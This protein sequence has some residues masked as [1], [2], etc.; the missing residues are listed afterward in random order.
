MKA[1]SAFSTFSGARLGP[2]RKNK[3]LGPR[4]GGPQVVTFA[5]SHVNRPL[6]SRPVSPTALPAELALGWSW[7]MVASSCLKRPTT[8]IC[9]SR[10][11]AV[12]REVGERGSL[13]FSWLPSLP[14]A[15]VRGRP[16]WSAALSSRSTTRLAVLL[17]CKAHAA[18]TRDD[19]PRV[20][21]AWLNGRGGWSA[22]SR[23]W[24]RRP[25]R[26]MAP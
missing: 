2:E 14:P 3:G 22:T 8:A 4:W 16:R 25:A 18:R 23:K 12:H 9:S 20:G 15:A 5:E 7:G 11:R 6:R 1:H 17:N 10:S 13:L 19:N 21:E 24:P 26:R